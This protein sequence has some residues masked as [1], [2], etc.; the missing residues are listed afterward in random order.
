MDLVIMV[1]WVFGYGNDFSEIC[2]GI[3][4]DGR[5]GGVGGCWWWR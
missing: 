3:D 5:C 2:G 1:L 4:G